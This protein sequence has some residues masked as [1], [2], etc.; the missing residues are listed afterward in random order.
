[1]GKAGGLGRSRWD[2][3]KGKGAALNIK[4]I[5]LK[6]R[7][8]CGC[9]KQF[10]DRVPSQFLIADAMLILDDRLDQNL[11]RFFKDRTCFF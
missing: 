10:P 4:A 2:R 7:R 1:M 6:F 5:W 9:A 11:L 3:E 8:L